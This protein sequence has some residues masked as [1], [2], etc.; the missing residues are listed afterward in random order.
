[1]GHSAALDPAACSETVIHLPVTVLSPHLI[2]S[3]PRDFCFYFKLWSPPVSENQN[4]TPT[5]LEHVTRVRLVT[6]VGKN[7]VWIVF[8]SLYFCFRKDLYNPA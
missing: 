7:E 6:P 3:H 2:L 8:G 1:M 5:A 4:H